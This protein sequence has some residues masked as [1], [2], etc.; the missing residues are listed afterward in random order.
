MNKSEETLKKLKSILEMIRIFFV[1]V[2]I[3]K[4]YCY[5][6]IRGN[7]LEPTISMVP[8]R[9]PA[10]TCSLGFA[11]AICPLHVIC[12]AICGPK[13]FHPACLIFDLMGL[14]IKGLIG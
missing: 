11:S 13:K 14:Q 12:K 2:K 4:H 3:G 8:G 5:G 9:A 1:S 6:N 10:K 7:A